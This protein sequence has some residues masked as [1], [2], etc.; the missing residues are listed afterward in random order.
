[1]NAQKYCAILDRVNEKTKTDLRF[2]GQIFFQQDNARPHTA[3]ITKEK[4]KELRW[5]LIPHP[6]YSPDL[7]PSDYHVFR[8]M[9]NDQRGRTFTSDEEAKDATD[10][11]LQ[12]KEREEGFYR[13]GIEK[14]T[15]RWQKCISVK[16]EYFEE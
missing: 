6:P 7:A 15:E 2:R 1:M 13:R 5:K 3:K 8:S 10:S 9:A 12:K 14:L 4:I 11:F 16:G